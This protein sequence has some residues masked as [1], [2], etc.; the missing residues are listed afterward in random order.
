MKQY[1][2]TFDGQGNVTGHY[3]DD[4]N[5]NIPSLLLN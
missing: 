2:A 1:Y 4:I 5:D 3:I